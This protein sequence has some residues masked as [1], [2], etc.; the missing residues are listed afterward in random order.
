[1]GRYDFE[2]AAQEPEKQPRGK[3][4]FEGT[5]LAPTGPTSQLGVPQVERA[6]GPPPPVPSVSAPHP[7]VGRLA[8]IEQA[9]RV[10]G[11]PTAAGIAVPEPESI[12]GR[13]ARVLSEGL[14]R[15]TLAGPALHEAGMPETRVLATDPTTGRPVVT[16]REDTAWKKA[17]RSLGTV[18]SLAEFPVTFPIEVTSAVAKHFD[19]ETRAE[20]EEEI[21]TILA[22]FYDIPKTT[23]D[24][25][26]DTPEFRRRYQEDPVHAISNVALSALMAWH[27]MGRIKGKKTRRDPATGEKITEYKRPG[28]GEPM[29]FGELAKDLL[30]EPVRPEVL[31]KAAA[32]AE[33]RR[34]P[35]RALAE[36]I[37]DRPE[38]RV[39]FGPEDFPEPPP[40]RAPAVPPESGGT[41]Y[42]EPGPIPKTEPLPLSEAPEGPRGARAREF[43]EAS[44]EAQR[45]LTETTDPAKQAELT[46][47]SVEYD[48]RA[49]EELESLGATEAM[50]AVLDE[51]IEAGG[52]RVDV[53]RRQQ[54]RDEAVR[55]YRKELEDRAERRLQG[56]EDVAREPDLEAVRSK[57]QT[58]ESQIFEQQEAAKKP[59]R[60]RP[61]QA[62]P[63]RGAERPPQP[64]AEPAAEAPAPPPAAR[65]QVGQTVK[66]G[67]RKVKIV[68]EGEKGGEPVFRVT[69]RGLG[70][71]GRAG[72]T[73]AELS[74]WVEKPRK[75]GG[76]K[77]PEDPRTDPRGL[78]Y[79]VSRN[80]GIYDPS[81]PGETRAV[82]QAY[83]FPTMVGKN[84]MSFEALAEFLKGTYPDIWR[85]QEAA[86]D[87]VGEWR[88]GMEQ[89]KGVTPE[90]GVAAEY[91]VEVERQRK[92]TASRAGEQIIRMRGEK[93]I[94]AGKQAIRAMEKEP[95]KI[96]EVDL[97]AGDVLYLPEQKDVF[98]VKTRGGETI[99]QDGKQIRVPFGQTVEGVRLGKV[100]TGRK[101]GM[102]KK[103]AEAAKPTIKDEAQW[104]S[105]TIDPFWEQADRPF[106]TPGGRAYSDYLEKPETRPGILKEA[107]LK[108]PPAAD[109]NAAIKKAMPAPPTAEAALPG[110]EEAAARTAKGKELAETA[111]VVEGKRA[112]DVERGQESLLD[113]ETG[114]KIRKG[115]KVAAEEAA[116][117]EKERSLFGEKYG[118]DNIGVDKATA[119]KA[120]AALRKKT[121][122]LTA[123]VDPTTV[124]ELL[125]LGVYHAEALARAAARGVADFK[126]WSRNVIRDAMDLGIM[127][128]KPQVDT[129]WRHAKIQAA[130]A[131]G[132]LTRQPAPFPTGKVR[133]FM[134]ELG[135]KGQVAVDEWRRATNRINL[136]HRLVHEETAKRFKGLSKEAKDGIYWAARGIPGKNVDGTYRYGAIARAGTM[137][138]Y[139]GKQRIAPRPGAMLPDGRV[140]GYD[141][142]GTKDVQL[143]RVIW[144]EEARGY[145]AELQAKHPKAAEILDEYLAADEGSVITA[146]GDRLPAFSRRVLKEQYGIEGLSPDEARAASNLI[147]QTL[148]EGAA[149]RVIPHEF[150][151][152]PESG[153]RSGTL[154]GR[155]RN[156]LRPTTAGARK[157]KRG[158]TGERV[159]AAR[160][161]GHEFWVDMGKATERTRRELARESIHNQMAARLLS[162]VAE[163]I[164][165][166]ETLE[167]IEAEGYV[168]F[169][170]TGLFKDS[171]RVRRFFERNRDFF[172]EQGIDVPEVVDATY[173]AGGKGLKIPSVI[174]ERLGEMFETKPKSVDPQLR[175]TIK[176]L[177]DLGGRVI[178]AINVW[179]LS[180]PSTAV[181]NLISNQV[182]YSAKVIRDFYRE[183]MLMALK[184]PQAWAA[185]Y[186]ETMSDIR[187]LGSSLGKKSREKIPNELLGHTFLDELQ[188]GGTVARLG[189]KWLRINGFNY[190]DIYTKRLIVEAV[191]DAAARQ[192]WALAKKTG[193]T[194]GLSKSQFIES[195][196][197]SVPKDV[198]SLAYREMDTWGGYDYQ[199]VAPTLE[200]L[201]KSKTFRAVIPYPTY[202][203]KLFGTYRELFGVRNLTTL[204]SKHANKRAKANAAANLLTGATM[205]AFFWWLTD[206][207]GQ[208]PDEINEQDIPYEYQ[209]HGRLPVPEKA[210][211]AVAGDDFKEGLW[212]RLYDLPF[213]GEVMAARAIWGNELSVGDYLN[214]R[215]ALGP[216]FNTVAITAGLSNRYNRDLPVASRLGREISSWFPLQAEANAVRRLID[217][218]KRE[219]GNKDKETSSFKNFLGGFADHYPML[220]YLLNPRYSKPRHRVPTYH[221]MEATLSYF[222]LNTRF[223]D[224]AERETAILLARQAA[225]EDTKQRL[226]KEVMRDYALRTMDE[227]GYT[228]GGRIKRAAKLDETELE[229]ATA[230]SLFSVEI[231]QA[232]QEGGSEAAWA[233]REELMQDEEF[234]RYA[235][236]KANRTITNLIKRL[237]TV[238]RKGVAYREFQRA[239]GQVKEE[240]REETKEEMQ[241]IRMKRAVNE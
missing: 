196:K 65:F 97:E 184:D 93:P 13:V 104:V 28:V 129:L 59:T 222:L 61:V 58:L 150:S 102:K 101:I 116:F 81:L 88:R 51:G 133:A 169:S 151:Y 125:T 30:K 37:T 163:T 4:D 114:E 178:G 46:R 138:A 113:K 182:I 239:P 158:T 71:K 237:Q 10:G 228:L 106:D 230:K 167:S 105:D 224:E 202:Y 32:A 214:D 85:T 43:M 233:K 82:K 86:M 117:K 223:I 173:V 161:E 164:K 205:T 236:G 213:L 166:G 160:E 39:A 42:R 234:S 185:P 25:V 47:R 76:P 190:A 175:A 211:K 64:A 29:D 137:R 120:R 148:G 207:E 225:L 78:A 84:G 155:L 90:R 24:I 60:G 73:E 145:H 231:L 171:V 134:T 96:S 80:G 201:K 186:V 100:E 111:R 188:Q 110:F 147:R 63:T 40:E 177:D 26:M 170:K 183:T 218:I 126:Q 22:E 141:L 240:F 3:Y 53:T 217:P 1:M 45:Q 7:S 209:K 119:E 131:S 159:R 235:R 195:Y 176:A 107:G 118:E 20:G 142:P 44:E 72:V 144:P 154:V 11:E 128:T 210:V 191:Y 14:G 68:E 152:V 121:S 220:S 16:E 136:M 215:I 123:G 227:R 179:R 27:G 139:R 192:A 36:P 50:E 67:R 56:E 35:G 149:G 140:V 41:Q 180:R 2:G 226:D 124:K 127:L 89:R 168:S 135:K 157:F 216:L 200:K 17:L 52:R 9:E 95:E 204:A 66:M 19:P 77:L 203:Y 57:L 48:K 165:K 122:G 79:W 187:A 206:D 241:R 112:R 156:A 221:P 23:T 115:E 194:G 162:L 87:F 109:P 174:A 229:I 54:I 92:R 132:A 69:G 74:E 70:R 38:G 6:P 189:G 146:A 108:K 198:E 212:V 15:A 219:A 197:R 55:R 18:A 8:R 5:G 143:Y 75:K 99:L 49:R 31:E 33:G 12:P 193:E 21:K 232:F 91:D 94:A 199:N 62:E 153:F 34:E 103:P 238:E 208:L 181:R 98:R 130:R 83:P 172:E